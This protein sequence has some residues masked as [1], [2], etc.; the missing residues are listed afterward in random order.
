[1][2]AGG[3]TGSS[4]GWA[5]GEFVGGFVTGLSPDIAATFSNGEYVST[6]LQQDMS[7]YR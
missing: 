2:Y 3:F 1:M 4:I 7:A 6:V 5:V